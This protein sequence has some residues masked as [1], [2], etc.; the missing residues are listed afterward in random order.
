MTFTTALNLKISQPSIWYTLD[1][2]IQDANVY[3]DPLKKLPAAELDMSTAGQGQWAGNRIGVDMSGLLHKAIL[4]CAQELCS[5]DAPLEVRHK[6]YVTS[7]LM[8]LVDAGWRPVAVFDGAEWVLKASENDSRR[9]KNADMLTAAQVALEDNRKAD[10]KNLF[11]RAVR[12]PE[13][14]VPWLI[15]K[16]SASSQMDLRKLT[17]G[18]ILELTFNEV[19]L[20]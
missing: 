14:F 11:K 19:G 15:T 2:G 20:N 8:S 9:A 16:I 3:I 6:N 13:D 4:P 1:M 7:R 18:S 12:V 10:A 5:D 17:N